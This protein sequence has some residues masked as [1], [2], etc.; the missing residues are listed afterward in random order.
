MP[1]AS[2]HGDVIEQQLRLACADLDRRLRGGE[3]VR[4]ERLLA[5]YPL[6]AAHEDRAVEL[7]YTEFVTREELKGRPTY[8]E[9][10][11]RFP[12]WR[13]HLGRLFQVHQ[14]LRDSL[15]DDAP[16]D[17]PPPPAEPE[18][19]PRSRLGQYQLLEEVARGGCGAVY[20][21]LQHGLERVVALKV[22][23]PEFA[24]QRRARRR[25]WHEAKVMG[26]LRHPNVMP[27]HEIGES[28]GLIYISMD[29]MPA[30][31]L[32]GRLP[33]AGPAA[34]AEALRLLATVAGAVDYAHRQ[35]VI[36]C[37]LKPSNILLD[38][39]GAPVVSD[40]GL[41]RLRRGEAERDGPI[42]GTPAYMAPEQMAGD[43]PFTAATDVWALGVILYE[44]LAGHRPFSGR[45]L[46]DL[47]EAVCAGEPP[48]LEGLCPPVSARRI[49]VCRRCLEKDP[50]RRY[51]SAAELADA[52]RDA[53]PPV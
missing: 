49:T 38:A 37:D 48:P 45:T 9:F 6:L 10:Y 12:Q 50:A 34:A 51:A 35:G 36:H 33:P 20:K 8:E 47:R 5:Q 27:V 42:V 44:V 3:C 39:Q 4:A 7:V 25:F 23:L 13:E 30:G 46:D 29:F 40:F 53:T 19:G 18:P 11:A 1:A 21:A 31:S 2:A 32:A 41:A 43:G 26:A 24:R 15:T 52:L 16:A 17:L 22:L 28:D 14:L